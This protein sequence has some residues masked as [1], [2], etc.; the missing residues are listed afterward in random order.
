MLQFFIGLDHPATRL[1]VSPNTPDRSSVSLSGDMNV[2]RELRSH[3][4]SNVVRRS[5]QHLHEASTA[6]GKAKLLEE[7]KQFVAG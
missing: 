7:L 4:A 5:S 6:Q 2:S 1:A 3:L